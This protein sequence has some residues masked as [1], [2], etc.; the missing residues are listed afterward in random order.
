MYYDKNKSE[1]I[2]SKP[3]AVTELRCQNLIDSIGIDCTLS[4]VSWKQ[5]A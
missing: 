1:A 5:I 4:H 3:L 2:K